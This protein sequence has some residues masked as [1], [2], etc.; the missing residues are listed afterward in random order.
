M[1]TSLKMGVHACVAVYLLR[2]HASSPAKRLLQRVAGAADT[3]RVQ[4]STAGGKPRAGAAFHLKSTGLAN[5][6]RLLAQEVPHPA[7]KM[8]RE[9]ACAGVCV[10]LTE[11]AHLAGQLRHLIPQGENFFPI[12][13]CDQILP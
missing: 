6:I 7:L 11:V 5:G 4:Y 3:A 2:P 1:K 12:S 8:A 9:E 13:A 10:C